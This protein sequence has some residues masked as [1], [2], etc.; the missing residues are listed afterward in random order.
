MVVLSNA[1][2]HIG[3]VPHEGDIFELQ[4]YSSLAKLMRVATCVFK[5]VN[6]LKRN[7]SAK[8]C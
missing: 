8:L 3:P 2:Q 1:I 7:D 6:K 5:F 4:R